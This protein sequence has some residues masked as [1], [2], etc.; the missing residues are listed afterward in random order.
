MF[1]QSGR[2]LTELVHPAMEKPIK[3]AGRVLPE[4]I[5]DAVWGY[6]SLYVASFAAIML[7]L[8][9]DGMDQVTAFSSVATSINNFGPGLGEVTA[10]FKSITT[11]SKWVL[12]FAMLLGRLEI[13]TLLVIFTPSFWRK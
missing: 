12:A 6:F 8:M 4:R 9:A 2:D 7:L 11:E 3:I 13:F 5:I 1:K 10:N